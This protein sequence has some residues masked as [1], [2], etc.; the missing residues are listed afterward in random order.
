EA[1]KTKEV[2]PGELLA[3]HIREQTKREKV[4]AFSVVTLSVPDGLTREQVRNLLK[5]PASDPAMASIAVIKGSKDIYFY[6]QELMTER[7]ATVQSL[8]EDKDILATVASAARHECKVYPRP[9]RVQSLMD[10]PYFYSEDEVLGALARMKITDTY[11]DIDTVTA[12]NG[13][14]CIYS[15][16]YMSKKYAQALCEQLEVE[17]RYCQ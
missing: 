7:F 6:D 4:V 5:D 16:L 15:S 17:W 11:E 10:S 3:K 1:E 2:S 12:S 8:I 14:M 9:L 13:K